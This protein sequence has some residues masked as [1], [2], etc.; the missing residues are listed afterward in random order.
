MST[1]HVH[2]AE[3][4]VD[5]QLL[6]C[7]QVVIRAHPVESNAFHSQCRTDTIMYVPPWCPKRASELQLQDAEDFEHVSFGKVIFGLTLFLFVIRV[8]DRSVCERHA[9]S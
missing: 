8:C 5:W 3:G 2:S 9:K 6:Y 4:K 1:C 7:G